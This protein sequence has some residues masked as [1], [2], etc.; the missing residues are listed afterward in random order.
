MNSEQ[1]KQFKAVVD[2]GGMTKA[3]NAL[4]ITQP[5]ISKTNS[6]FEIYYNARFP[7]GLYCAAGS[8]HARASRR[9]FC[10]FADVTAESVSSLRPH[11]FSCRSMIRS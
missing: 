10:F 8:H 1:L 5:A 2:C 6:D 7:V 9:A 3:S 11:S 4:Y